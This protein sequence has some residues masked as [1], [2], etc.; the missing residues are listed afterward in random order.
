M[1]KRSTQNHVSFALIYKQLKRKTIFLFPSPLILHQLGWYLVF[2]T[3]SLSLNIHVI[4]FGNNIHFLIVVV[5]IILPS[6]SYYICN[7]TIKILFSFKIKIEHGSSFFSI[8]LFLQF[9]NFFFFFIF[10]IFYIL[11]FS[12]SFYV[13]LTQPY[14]RFLF[15]FSISLSLNYILFDFRF[16]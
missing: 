10:V 1:S 13:L 9:V 5:Y 11:V 14:L 8:F 2:T 12:F 15:L 3:L 6:Q 16:Y 7:V 4:F